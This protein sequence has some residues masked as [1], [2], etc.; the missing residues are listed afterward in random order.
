MDKEKAKFDLKDVWAQRFWIACGIIAITCVVVFFITNSALNK[1]R[2]QR[3]SKIKQQ[4]SVVESVMN[5][6][7]TD[8]ANIKVH[9]NATTQK[10]MEGEINTGAKAAFEAWQMR[11]DNQQQYLQWPEVISKSIADNLKKIDHPET[12]D[13]LDWDLTR[14]QRD[15]FREQ[16]V[17]VMPG[18]VDKIKAKWE[19]EKVNTKTKNS[20]GSS[21]ASMLEERK[22]EPEVVIWES[23]NQAIWQAKLTQFGGRNGNADPTGVPT[24]MQIFSLQQDLW[25]L[26]AVFDIIDKV[27]EDASA[28]DFAKVKRIDHILI[29]REAGG[30]GTVGQVTDAELAA[31]GPEKKKAQSHTGRKER[32]LKRG[33]QRSLNSYG[34]RRSAK[35]SGT[36][37]A[38]F[39]PNESTSPFHG[40]YVNWD[41]EPVN[42]SEIVKALTSDKLVDDSYL[43]VAR[44]IPVRVAVRM[45]EREIE[46]FLAACANSPFIFEVH[47]VRVN[48]HEI[49]NGFDADS[50]SNKKKRDG[51]E[52][53]LGSLNVAGGQGSD[54]STLSDGNDDRSGGNG[55]SGD[56]HSP[57]KRV[58]FDIDV[59]FYG[60]VK[61][62]NTPDEDILYDRKKTNKKQGTKPGDDKKAQVN[63][64]NING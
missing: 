35:S 17:D 21:D 3:T 52:K 56:P 8:T 19:F 59:E 14:E 42:N 30:A 18:L 57:E 47:R 27:N 38:G 13:Q 34:S 58:N 51:N 31:K 43:H 1:E 20:Q 53:E 39:S 41:F 33:R 36:K 61:L 49:N 15:T 10:G 16:I 29:G 60:V 62:Y 37:K 11:F 45:D 6:G 40:R 50:V 7:T 63:D 25:L 5:T 28:N 32:G 44:R 2:E 64:P 22:K 24:T 46:N 23:D 55:G 9:P 12:A 4:K 26:G 54:A 48:E